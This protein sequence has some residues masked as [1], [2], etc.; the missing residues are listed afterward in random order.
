MGVGALVD[1]K[2]R[3]TAPGML[4]SD[5]NGRSNAAI[6][7]MASSLKDDDLMISSS[8]IDINE[9][10]NMLTKTKL[11]TNDRIKSGK[12]ISPS[13][14]AQDDVGNLVIKEEE[15]SSLKSVSPL[16]ETSRSKKSS[17]ISAS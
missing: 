2:S 11:E 5:R 12:L 10:R 16:T 4:P 9:A 6:T 8:Q 17:R 14:A 15:N 13:A 1:N 3:A 7:V